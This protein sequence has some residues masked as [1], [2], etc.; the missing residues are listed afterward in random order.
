MRCHHFKNKFPID[1]NPPVPYKMQWAGKPDAIPPQEVDI[2]C[3]GEW[4]TWK[5]YTGMEWSLRCPNS[6]HSVRTDQILRYIKETDLRFDNFNVSYNSQVQEL[7]Q[8]Q[9]FPQSQ[10]KKL[11]LIGDSWTGK[12]RLAK[13]LFIHL[14]MNGETCVF[15]NAEKLA[16]IIRRDQKDDSQAVNEMQELWQSAWLFIDDLGTERKT[17]TGLFEIKLKVILDDYRGRMVF[18]T[19]LGFP[20][21]DKIP[22]SP[23]VIYYD[24]RL[25]NRLKAGS[26]IIPFTGRPYREKK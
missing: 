18:T 15:Y 6:H 21:K 20:T 3:D 1:G 26:R 10:L 9:A 23:G 13:T 22:G 25:I 17:D 14:C 16:E 5:D 19:N 24:E 2:F 8:V 12:T 11:I 4:H 7:K